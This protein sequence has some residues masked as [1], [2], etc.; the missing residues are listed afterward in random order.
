MCKFEDSDESMTFE[1]CNLFKRSF[2]TQGLG[3]TFNNEEE[4]KLIK[5]DYR[6]ELSVNV[7]RKPYFRVQNMLLILSCTT[8][9]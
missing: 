4:S 8:Y 6:S 2:T 3:F 1:N 9:K 7:N 5:E